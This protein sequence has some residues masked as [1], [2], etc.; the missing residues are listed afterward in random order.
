MTPETW[1]PGEEARCALLD[2]AYGKHE[3]A[4]RAVERG[5][6]ARAARMAAASYA[7]PQL[8]PLADASER[9]WRDPPNYDAEHAARIALERE[10]RSVLEAIV[11]AP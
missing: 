1:E 11:P 7:A 2:L 4:T 5:M 8:L 6:V 9:A 3:G 10:A